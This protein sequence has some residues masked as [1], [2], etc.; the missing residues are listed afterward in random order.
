MRS[1]VKVIFSIA[2]SASLL[3]AL[4]S[5]G[6]RQS[7]SGSKPA[8]LQDLTALKSVGSPEAPITIEVFSDYQCAQCRASYLDTA[9]QLMLTYIPAGTGYYVLQD[10]TLPLHTHFR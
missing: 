6:P 3:P 1:C 7:S 4:L 5:A 2:L 8:P 10:F 9:L